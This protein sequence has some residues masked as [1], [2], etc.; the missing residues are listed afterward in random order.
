MPEERA[1]VD[2]LLRIVGSERASH[3]AEDVAE[4][5]RRLAELARTNVDRTR[6]RLRTV[7]TVIALLGALFLASAAGPSVT[8][9]APSRKDRA[10]WPKP[11]GRRF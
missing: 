4:A 2:E 11:D 9:A 7:G 1:G 5:E 10:A 3:S 8:V 6:T